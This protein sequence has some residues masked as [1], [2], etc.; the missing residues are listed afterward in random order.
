[1]PTLLH[2][3][4]G[5]S[6]C[7]RL[8]RLCKVER[9]IP[10]RDGL[11]RSA[12][13]TF[14]SN[15]GVNE[16]RRPVQRL[17]PLEVMADEVDAESAATAEQGYCSNSMNSDDLDVIILDHA[18]NYT[19]DPR[20]W[21]RGRPSSWSLNSILSVFQ[22]TIW[23]DSWVVRSSWIR[24]IS[25]TIGTNNSGKLKFL[26]S[27]NSDTD[28]NLDWVVDISDCIL[29]GFSFW[30]NMG[31]REHSYDENSLKVVSLQF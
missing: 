12:V 27:G 21:H 26:S 6:F 31:C 29:D 10:G 2:S 1:M 22:D 7:S 24:V 14:K 11:V 20:W 28:C 19:R 8:W 18:Y 17:F 30:P 23:T 9:L 5:L 4:D 25:R 15:Y 3:P 13:V 16:F